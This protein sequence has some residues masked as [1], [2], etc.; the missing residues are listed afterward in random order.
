MRVFQLTPGCRLAVLAILAALPAAALP[1]PSISQ[2]FGG[3]TVAIG[4]AMT[5]TFTVSTNGNTFI[6][7]TGVGFT[8]ALTG[9]A[10]AAVPGVTNTCGGV[11]TAVAGSTSIAL[12]GGSVLAGATCMV[13]VNITGTALGSQS[14][15]SSGVSA[16]DFGTAGGSDA[17]ITV[18]PAI[19][20][21]AAPASWMLLLSGMLAMM[22]WNYWQARLRRRSSTAGV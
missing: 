11:V 4:G 13:S 8:D 9:L 2:V 19:P 20:T 5:L 7:L 1:S 6:N 15:V 22:V 16:D 3:A 14:S 17:A 18:T 21:G 10:V 12:T